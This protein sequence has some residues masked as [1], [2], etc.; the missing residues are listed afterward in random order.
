MADVVE[1]ECAKLEEGLMTTGVRQRPS[2][3]KTGPVRTLFFDNAS[4]DFSFWTSQSDNPAVHRLHWKLENFEVAA[5][6]GG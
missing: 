3:R 2:G 6:Y 5:C 1:V 4:I